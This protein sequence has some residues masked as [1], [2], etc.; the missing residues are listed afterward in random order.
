MDADTYRGQSEYY[1]VLAK[2]PEEQAYQNV[3]YKREGG[4]FMGRPSHQDTPLTIDVAEE[5]KNLLMA[6]GYDVVIASR[7][8]SIDLDLI[9]LHE[10]AVRRA[11]KDTSA[12]GCSPE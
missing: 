8:K 12:E 7:G 3:F 11:Q 2:K 4:C 9:L 6:R 5:A 10:E 1:V